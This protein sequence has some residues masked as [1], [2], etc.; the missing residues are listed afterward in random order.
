M[1][2]VPAVQVLPE[3]RWHKK[4]KDNICGG[5][6]RTSNVQVHKYKTNITQTGDHKAVRQTAV[7]ESMVL[8][9]RGFKNIYAF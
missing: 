2:R 8:A 1:D 5:F 3:M 6:H 4:V 7:F 9:F